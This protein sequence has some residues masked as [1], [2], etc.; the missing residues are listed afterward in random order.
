MNI[1]VAIAMYLISVASAVQCGLLPCVPG[2][3]IWRF[4]RPTRTVMLEW[5]KEIKQD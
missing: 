3:K 4:V 2:N 1:L 5:G